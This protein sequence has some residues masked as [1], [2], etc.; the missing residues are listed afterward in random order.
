VNLI[1]AV[2][3]PNLFAKYFRDPATWRAWRVFLHALFALPMPDDQLAIFRECTARTEAPSKAFE[4]AW[5]ICGR[6]GG[7]SFTLGLIAVYLATFFDWLPFL[8]VGERGYVVVVAADRKQARVIMQYISSLLRETPMLEKMIIRET[9]EEIDLDNRITIEVATC[10]FRTI[11]GRTIVAALAD[12]L[13]FWLSEGSANPDE[14]VLAA[15]RPAMA[16]IPGARLLC[17]SSPHAR[18]G[19]LFNAYQRYYGKNDAPV[20][21]WKAPTKTMNPTVAQRIIDEAYEADPAVA[22]AEYGAEF[23][24][25]VERLLTREAVMACVKVGILERQPDRTHNYM[26][27][28]DPSGGSGDSFTLA[29]AHKEGKTNIL[30][31]V[32]ERV[33]PFSPEATIEEF[34]GILKKYRIT[35]VRGDKYAGEFPRE[36]FRKHG[37]NYEPADKTKS[38]L[39]GDLVATINSGAVDLLDHGK[40]ISQLIGLDRRTRSGGRDQI[41]HAPGGHDDIAN[42]V[43]GAVLNADQAAPANFHK[44]IEYPR[45][46][47]A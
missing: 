6:R 18:R 14:E 23:R 1:E 24:T 22:A 8:T 7:K 29:I 37:V 21:V 19:A 47:V 25:D 38:E 41:D 4:E 12:E 43:A 36:Q 31:L 33:P 45:M 26:A 32:R 17:A 9:A 27:F 42:A 2:D 30:D 34:A 46:S 10:S 20:L 39:Y 13:A 35:S 11:R 40:L 3:D 5:L 28:T 15:I 16:T 44:R